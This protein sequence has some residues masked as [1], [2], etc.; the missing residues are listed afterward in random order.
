MGST[1]RRRSDGSYEE[2]DGDWVGN[3]TRE[4]GLVTG[5][6]APRRS[7][8]QNAEV[9][10]LKQAQRHG[11]EFVNPGQGLATD[12]EYAGPGHGQLFST[13]P[14]EADPA[15]VLRAH[16]VPMRRESAGHGFLP[17]LG[18]VAGTED[19]T[20]RQRIAGVKMK[21][22]EGANGITGVVQHGLADSPRDSFHGSGVA[23]RFPA[24]FQT[25]HG[26]A[27]ARQ[28]HNRSLHIDEERIQREHDWY[29]VESDAVG[30]V[31][32][33]VGVPHAAARRTTAL[34][35]P[36]TPWDEGQTQDS[37]YLQYNLAKTRAVHEVVNEAN[38][39]GRDPLPA[40]KRMKMADPRNPNNLLMS[41]ADER[42]RMLTHI[43]AEEQHEPLVSSAERNRPP[44]S[45]AAPPKGEKVPNFDVALART[46]PSQ[47]AQR[48]AAQSY[49]VDT[50]DARAAGIPQYVQH[51]SGGGI[52]K[53]MR[54][55][56]EEKA[57]RGEVSPTHWSGARGLVGGAQYDIAA[58]TGR[59]A[60]LKAEMLP[61]NSQQHQWRNVRK[62][63]KLAQQSLF[64]E[65]GKKLKMNPAA[66]PVVNH[67]DDIF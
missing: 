13:E 61:S 62:P 33:Q 63:G 53:E 34:G 22:L 14:Y 56:L 47:T 24:G 16:G 23:I 57:Q 44:G 6:P 9:T 51:I 35:S 41:T 8:R 48:Q 54:P 43:E 28:M 31:A 10:A 12:A 65:E 2:S 7:S 20:E 64:V 39:K 38:A 18:S 21:A 49:T 27:L 40:L 29:A 42:E 25:E 11:T 19:P 15:D 50:H 37:T 45:K 36:Q 59:R 46:V 32:Y 30:E 26:G 5:R 55:A 60:G 66:L 52:P 67:D 1:F 17:R 58:M 4:H 3:S